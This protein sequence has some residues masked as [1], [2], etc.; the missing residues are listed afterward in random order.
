MTIKQQ[1]VQ[2]NVLL[3]VQND[4]TFDQKTCTNSS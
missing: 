2:T 1:Q 3:H 4:C